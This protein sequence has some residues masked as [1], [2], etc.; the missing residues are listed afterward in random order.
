MKF[1][2][3]LL[4]KTSINKKQILKIFK[5]IKPFKFRLIEEWLVI[6]R[7]KRLMT[8]NWRSWCPNLA[9]EFEIGVGNTDFWINLKLKD[10][11]TWILEEKC[12]T[13]I[14][15]ERMR[16]IFMISLVST[17]NVHLS[18]WIN[19][20]LLFYG[21]SNLNG[22]IFLFIFCLNKFVFELE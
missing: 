17:R 12:T 18:N 2:P 9:L 1:E 8:F 15:I 3:F 13:V 6:N 4:K 11:S 20:R 14:K 22:H 5:Y 19:N 16:K 7:M 21:N 10:I